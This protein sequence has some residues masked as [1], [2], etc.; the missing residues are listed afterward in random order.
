[1]SW[2]LLLPPPMPLPPALGQDHLAVAFG[3]GGAAAVVALVE[4]GG[5]AD[6]L[7][8]SRMGAPLRTDR[9]AAAAAQAVGAR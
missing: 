3:I 9:T 1:M 7:H 8:K 5:A 4:A 2:I 6:P